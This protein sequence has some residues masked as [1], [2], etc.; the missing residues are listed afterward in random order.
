[1][2]ILRLEKGNFHAR[3]CVERIVKLCLKNITNIQG[4]NAC[5]F[6]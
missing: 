1:M 3:D 2:N 6:N 5:M 4:K